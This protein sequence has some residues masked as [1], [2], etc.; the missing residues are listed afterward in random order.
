MEPIKKLF[1]KKTHSIERKQARVIGEE[2]NF[3]VVESYKTIR[4]NLIFATQK[5]G[6]KRV[7]ITSSV[8]NEGKSINCCNLGITMAQ[9]NSRVLIIDCDLRKPTVHKLLKLKGIPGLSELLA[10][11]NEVAECI[12]SSGY[13]NLDILSA[14]TIPPNPAELL[15]SE[16][17]DKVLENL[18]DEYDYILLDT[19]PV[20]VVA[21]AMVLSP[22]ADGVVLVVREGVTTHPEMKHSLA[23]LE[24]GKAKVLGIIL[25]GVE[26]GS[27]Y[28]YSRYGYGGRKQHYKEYS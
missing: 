15:S 11:M 5:A 23:S 18:S 14:G 6:C 10:G 2:T 13:Q 3:S 9:T 28:G 19:P 26:T 1:K 12:Q 22:K 7:I 20:N 8:P 25:N 27:R 24:F 17:M 16:A 4:T 21:D